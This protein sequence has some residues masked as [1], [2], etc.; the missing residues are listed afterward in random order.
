MNEEKHKKL[1]DAMDAPGVCDECGKY[2]CTCPC[3]YCGN[4]PC[5]CE[6]I[7]TEW[8]DGLMARA[9]DEEPPETAC[10]KCGDD[11]CTCEA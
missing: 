9:D 4:N 6:A 7:V 10:G 1:V 3:G 2:P 8:N 11:P 5:T